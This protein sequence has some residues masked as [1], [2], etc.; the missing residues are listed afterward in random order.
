MTTER[1]IIALLF[2]K[3]T[4][5]VIALALLAIIGMF[6]YEKNVV[7]FD[8]YTQPYAVVPMKGEFEGDEQ[9]SFFVFSDTS[10]HV[11][12]NVK[13]ILMCD[14]V[15]GNGYSFVSSQE[16]IIEVERTDPKLASLGRAIASIDENSS[17][18]KTARDLR[19][20]V[21]KEDSY[22]VITFDGSLPATTSQCFVKL[23]FTKLTPNFNIEK[24]HEASSFPF[25]Y[26]WY[27]VPARGVYNTDA[28]GD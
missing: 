12:M 8:S 16:S 11:D 7:T 22:D 1:S 27:T 17:E 3:I 9:I 15:D 5:G 4:H 18:M 25:D 2:F 26:I 24:H 14:Y 23:K 19:R 28:L 6:V 21:G 10:S 20:L 13:K